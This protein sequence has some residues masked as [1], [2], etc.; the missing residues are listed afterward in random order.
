MNP[1]SKK[2]Q[3][4]FVIFSKKQKQG[5]KKEKL[6]AVGS[7]AGIILFIIQDRALG[8]QRQRYLRS[9]SPLNDRVFRRSFKEVANK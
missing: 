7:R 2:K 3:I 8:D 6:G 5:S 9:Q 4:E 1:T